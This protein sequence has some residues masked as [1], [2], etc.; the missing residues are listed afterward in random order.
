LSFFF[1]GFFFLAF[2]LLFLF[3]CSLQVEFAQAAAAQRAVRTGFVLVDGK[4]CNC[5]MGGRATDGG[6]GGFPGGGM[7][8]MGMAMGLQ[9]PVYKDLNDPLVYAKEQL[10]TAVNSATSLHALFTST[11]G[12]LDQLHTYYY[13]QQQSGLDASANIPGKRPGMGAPMDAGGLNKRPKFDGGYGAGGNFP[14][15]GG[16]HFNNTAPNWNQQNYY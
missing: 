9:R 12:V 2:S 10:L 4:N 1:L 14:G 16:G 6:F 7:M 3:A 15:A 11:R 8:G 5:R 13:N